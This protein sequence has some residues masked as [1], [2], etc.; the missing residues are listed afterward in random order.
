MFRL[1]VW[2]D[3]HWKWGIKT[4]S[5]MEEALRRVQQLKAAGIKA[6]VARE[7]ELFG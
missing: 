3:R 5:T 6:K 7:S 1:Q 2:F 4:Y